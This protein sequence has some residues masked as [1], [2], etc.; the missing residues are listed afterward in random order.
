M[1]DE[2]QDPPATTDG[3]PLEW[4]SRPLAELQ[5]HYDV[6]VVGSGYGGSIA[7]CRLARAGRKVALLER[8][9]ELHPGHFPR[10]PLSAVPAI[11]L[12]GANRATDDRRAL[13]WF[14]VSGEMNVLSGCGL[15]GT[16]LI[17]ASVSLRA[18]RSV[19]EDAR[20]PAALRRDGAGLDAAYERAEEILRPVTYPATSPRLR[21]VEALRELAGGLGFAMTPINVTFEPGANAV[22]VHQE[23]CNGC[24]D[25]VTG[26]NVGAKNTLLMNYLP[27][28]VAH[29]ASIF[30]ELD[31]RSIEQPTD[32]SPWVVHA[33]SLGT[34]RDAF[35]APPL[36]VTADVVVL[37]AGA[38]GSTGILL[39]SARE[40]LSLS[41]RLGECFS[42]NGDVLAFGVRNED[43][44][45]IG[46]GRSA[47]EMAEPAGPCITAVITDPGGGGTGNPIIV[48]DAV[49]PGALAPLVPAQ[50]APQLLP[51]WLRGRSG[52][53]P[54]RLLASMVSRGRRGIERR[55]ET[56][57]VMG[58]DDDRGRL[59]LDGDEVKVSWPGA[60][61]SP[62]YAAA[63][64]TVAALTERSG[65]TALADPIWTGLFHQ[66]LITV[67]P[68]GGCIMADD[69]E[70]GVVDDAGAVFSGSTGTAVHDGLYVWDGSVVPRPLGVNPLLTISALAER[71]VHLV[72]D[73]RG[74]VIDDSLPAG[75]PSGSPGPT[76]G[77]GSVGSVGGADGGAPVPAP[78]PTA[79][80]LRF[81]ERM[82]GH[83]SATSREAAD[84]EDYLQAARAGVAGAAGGSRPG[85]AGGSGSGAAG[86]D[87][88]GAAGGSAPGNAPNPSAS[89]SEGGE[90]T[91]VL[92]LATDDLG[93]VVA[94]LATPMSAVGTVEI[95]ALSPEPLAVERG[96]FQL[97]VADDAL[98]A[99]VSHMRYHLPLVATDGRRFHF[100]G[101]KVV[102]PGIVTDAWPETSTL[103]VTLRA[104]GPSGATLGL[105]VL[106]IAPADFGRQLRTMS[107]TGPV[108]E[109]E[110]L[111]LLTRFGRAFAGP[112][113]EHFGTVIHRSSRLVRDAPPRPHRPVDAPPPAVF[114]LV[115]ADGKAL[116][117]TRYD[118]GTNGHVV[119]SH[120]MGSNPSLFSLDTIEPNLVEYLTGHG[121]DVWLQEWRGSTLLPVSSEQFTADDVAAYDFPAAEALVARETGV[122]PTDIHWVAHCVGG[123]TVSM[124]ALAGTIRPR[125][126]AVSQVAAHPVGPRMTELK[127]RLHAAALIRATGIKLLTTDAYT[128][129]SAK[130]RMFDAALRLYPIPRAEQCD[131]AVCRR[132]GFIYGIAFHHEALNEATHRAIHELFAVTNLTMMNHLANCAARK[133][134]VGADGSDRYLSRLDR[135]QVPFTFLHGAKN[136][137]WVPESTQ[138]T[139]DLL[140]K[141]FGPSNYRRYVFSDHGHGDC[142]V[143]A[144]ASVDV[145]P[146]ILEHLERAGSG[147]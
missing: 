42:G 66:D 97:L 141:E 116:R 81:T 131:S 22:G 54:L 69:A 122:A 140:V 18:D 43:V 105:G 68:L 51:A 30:T 61:T 58:T 106:R 12:V 98:D 111:E 1:S 136:L 38:L 129:E 123:I 90:M 128:E 70:H 76:G 62:F 121:Y 52:A 73:R 64:G 36:A 133:R 78:L 114:P 24:G 72:A 104:S 56:F 32:G 29:G 44:G 145:Y 26:C 77:A 125:S 9:R 33:Q 7:A 95:P 117:M 147:P 144:S 10:N 101:F 46:A 3:R 132:L 119:L 79:P 89:A 60:G 5:A 28:A 4:L 34:G 134:I 53:G 15:G 71:A 115:T 118:G 146:K 120:G 27:D 48:E 74:W 80:R 82:S 8:G 45:G 103:Y 84:L 88:T 110:R 108:S 21:K 109:S 75:R 96:T 55:L 50:L 37:A 137:V 142:M 86:D 63:N 35:G 124:A 49:V 23:A 102:S 112:L 16:S 65:G 57:L 6:V 91:F 17:N 47:P 25:C 31:V 39:R 138:L 85:A 107:V 41:G 100:E 139:Y 20:W 126:I 40:G 83:W 19:L 92:T 13:F 14:H 67:H 113:V 130:A 99:S 93:S 135:L 2:P 143:G 11:Q 59:V 127:A 94:S 87:G